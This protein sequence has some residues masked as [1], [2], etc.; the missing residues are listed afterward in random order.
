[1]IYEKCDAAI[2]LPGGYGTLDELFEILTWNQLSIHNKPIY[3]LN[4]AGFYDSLLA[5]IKKMIAEN[6]LYT[7]MEDAFTIVTNPSEIFNHS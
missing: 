1:M 2:I 3:I 6:F 5:H 4:T 7:S